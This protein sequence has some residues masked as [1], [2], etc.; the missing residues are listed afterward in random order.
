MRDGAR[1]RQRAQLRLARPEV[2]EALRQVSRIGVGRTE[3]AMRLRP[4]DHLA[5]LLRIPRKRAG[6]VVV[7]G[8]EIAH[9]PARAFPFH[10]G[11]RVGVVAQV[12]EEPGDLRGG[13]PLVRPPV[14]RQGADRRGLKP[15]LDGERLCDLARL[16]D[17]VHAE[18]RR[19][20]AALDSERLFAV[21]IPVFVAFGIPAQAA[22]F[23]A[24]PDGRKKLAA[25]H[26]ALAIRQRVIAKTL[27]VHAPHGDVGQVL[28]LGIP[29]RNL[30][31]Q[32]L[33]ADR[34]LGLEAKRR[35]QRAVVTGHHGGFHPDPVAAQTTGEARLHPGRPLQ[36][37]AP[38]D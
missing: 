17:H 23:R 4:R 11:A 35:P 16:A 14:G 2:A 9:L 8:V 26:H 3:E 19:P 30:H 38:R 1:A 25:P 12:E 10:F 5:K 20:T 37:H 7:V 15:K 33:Q 36:R 29:N 18:E 21:G 13:N 22:L 31:A 27:I 6:E 34:L 24:D 32:P 28:R